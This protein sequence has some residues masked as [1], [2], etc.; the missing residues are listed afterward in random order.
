MKL[1]I[2]VCERCECEKTFGKLCDRLFFNC[3]KCLFMLDRKSEKTRTKDMKFI[4][5]Q[6]FNNKK[7][8]SVKSF[9]NCEYRV[10]QEL[11]NL[12]RKNK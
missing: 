4:S 5:L 2:K 6:D 1:N 7:L 9:E 8:F 3:S 12:C 10:E 11:F